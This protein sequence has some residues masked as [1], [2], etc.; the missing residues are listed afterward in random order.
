M[1][2]KSLDTNSIGSSSCTYLILLNR[3]M[4]IVKYLIR[5]GRSKMPTK[6]LTSYVN[7]PLFESNFHRFIKQKGLAIFGQK[8]ELSQ[9]VPSVEA[10]TA[11]HSAVAELL[12]TAKKNHI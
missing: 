3:L 6:Q 10:F 2:A 11:V 8:F 1:A 9:I 7:A 4:Y 5:V 12:K